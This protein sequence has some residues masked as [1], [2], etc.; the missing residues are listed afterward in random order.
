MYKISG[1]Y[2]T[3]AGVGAIDVVSAS[4]AEHLAQILYTQYED[5]YGVDMELEGEYDDGSDVN[6]TF[7]YMLEVLY[8]LAS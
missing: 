7:E 1:W 4:D 8:F 3:D 6:D 5:C 2:E